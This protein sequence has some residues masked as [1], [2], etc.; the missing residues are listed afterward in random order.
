MNGA[1]ATRTVLVD[2]LASGRAHV[3]G[4][5]VELSPATAGLLGGF[6]DR[7]HL[8]P[9]ADATLVGVAVGMAMAGTRPVVELAGPEA[10]PGALQQLVQEA[11]GVSGE[12][13]A[14]VV[15][16]VPVAP[17]AA[18][19]TPLLLGS[20]VTIACASCP[21]E[22]AALLQGAL[23]ADGPVVLLEPLAALSGGVTELP[24]LGLGRARVWQEGDHV[25]LL[26]WGDG[27]VAARHAAEMLAAEGLSVGVVDLRSIQPLDLDTVGVQVRHTGRFVLVGAPAGV[28]DAVVQVAFLRLEA[29]PASV[30]ADPDA[31]V[32]AARQAVSY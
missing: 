23:E 11:A 4:E 9:A 3:L 25:T 8:L 18:D 22:A 16:R 6:P 1:H 32:A 15:V 7:V 19:P 21:G 30:P 28:L 13:R 14:P 5:A 29:P 10:L 17:G 2:A 20:G 31:A 24:L 26:G 12:F 27:V